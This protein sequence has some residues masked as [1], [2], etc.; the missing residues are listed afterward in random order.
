MFTSGFSHRSYHLLSIPHPCQRLFV[1]GVRIRSGVF[2]GQRGLRRL[3]LR[4]LE[5]D[6]SAYAYHRSIS[7]QAKYRCVNL[8]MR[9]L[10]S[11]NLSCRWATVGLLEYL[12]FFKNFFY[13]RINKI[14]KRHSIEWIVTI[15][16]PMFEK[17][18]RE[19]CQSLTM[20]PEMLKMTPTILWSLGSL[21]WVLNVNWKSVSRSYDPSRN[22]S[23]KPLRATLKFVSL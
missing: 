5:E 17:H 10:G 8:V 15:F 16:I 4:P 2:S 22:W 3:L 13:F 9:M 6:M 7:P 20:L 21:R 14:H 1:H 23:F 18:S 19:P 12:Y 11:T